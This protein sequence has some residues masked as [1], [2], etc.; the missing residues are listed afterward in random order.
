MYLEINGVQYTCSKRI[1]KKDTIKYLS[2]IPEVKDI[3]GIAKL[4]RDDGFLLCEDNLDN[5]ERKYT[6]GTCLVVTNAPEPTPIDPTTTI[7]YRLSEVEE[8]KASKEDIQAIWD[9]MAQAY[10]EGVEQA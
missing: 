7:E 4:Y 1:T 8:N 2:V 10:Q 3:G 9:A 6:A 5:Y